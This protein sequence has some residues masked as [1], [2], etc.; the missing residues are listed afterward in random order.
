M[1]SADMSRPAE[2]R[3]KTVLVIRLEGEFDL[4]ERER[5]ASGFAVG[6][7][8]DNVALD[9]RRVRYVDSTVL[10]AVI[11][12]NRACKDRGAELTIFG[13]QD[14]VRRLFE[15][16]ALDTVLDLRSNYA[17][18]DDGRR[19]RRLTIESRIESS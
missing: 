10:S 17:V 18:P 11:A 8:A 19:V 9:F 13:A 1:E 3:A 7:T 16:T 5:L 15:V 4:G 6:H 14:Q 12:L 2:P